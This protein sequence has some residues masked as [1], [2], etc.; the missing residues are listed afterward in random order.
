MGIGSMTVTVKVKNMDKV[1]RVE[2]TWFYRS[3]GISKEYQL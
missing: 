1:Q 3:E 2:E